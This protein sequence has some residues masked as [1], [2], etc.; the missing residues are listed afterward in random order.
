MN[1]DLFEAAET[2]IK[3][4]EGLNLKPYLCPAGKLTIGYGRN[5]EDVGISEEEAVGL[6]HADITSAVRELEREFGPGWYNGMSRV[7]AA[8]LIDMMFNLGATRFGAFKKMIAAVRK[9]KWEKAADEAKNSKWYNQVG[10]RG[11]TIVRML[12][13]G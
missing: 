11:E 2:M 5:I 6:L 9:Q 7:R 3:R 12:R 10:G 13:E 8:A 1:L 4:H